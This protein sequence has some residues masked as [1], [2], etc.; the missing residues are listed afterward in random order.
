MS[1][2]YQFGD[3]M[4]FGSRDIMVLVYHV[5]S[6]DHL[7]KWSLNGHVKLRVE[8]SHGKSPACQIWWS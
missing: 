1:P 8:A 4:F 5:I 2:S 3:H 7:I 6:K